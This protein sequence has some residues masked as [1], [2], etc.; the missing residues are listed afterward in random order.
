MSEQDRSWRHA[1]GGGE[2]KLPRFRAAAV[3]A[4]PVYLDAVAT[5]EK[6]CALIR[7][8]AAHGA[9]LVAFP[10]VFV[11]GYPYWNW[12]LNPVEGSAWYEKLYRNAVDVPGPMVDLLAAC[13]RECAVTVVIGINERGPH[14]PRRHLQYVARH[15]P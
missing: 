15:R 11:P 10:E 2:L 3:Q 6:A 14:E 13:A 5:A 9:T 8:A 4:S 12:I 1:P 7:E